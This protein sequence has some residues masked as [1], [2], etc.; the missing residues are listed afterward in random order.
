[1]KAFC[2]KLQSNAECFDVSF[3]LWRFLA[4]K[5]TCLPQ[6]LVPLLEGMDTLKIKKYTRPIVPDA[7]LAASIPSPIPFTCC[8]LSQQRTVTT[9]CLKAKLFE[10]QGRQGLLFLQLLLLIGDI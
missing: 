6:L 9:A 2:L 3:S 4:V 10:V 7:T 8:N 5:C 1:M